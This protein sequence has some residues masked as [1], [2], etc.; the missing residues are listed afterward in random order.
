LLAAGELARELLLVAA[1]ADEREHFA[2]AAAISASST[3][4]TRSP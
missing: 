3:P 1:Q 2:D 4:R